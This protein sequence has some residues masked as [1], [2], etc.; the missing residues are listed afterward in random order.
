MTRKQPN[1]T[2]NTLMEQH[3]KF[4]GLDLSIQ[5]RLYRRH[6]AGYLLA[7]LQPAG[8]RRRL[9]FLGCQGD[10]CRSCTI[11]I[12]K[13]VQHPV[14][15]ALSQQFL[16]RAL[17]ANLAVMKHDDLIRSLHGREAVRHYN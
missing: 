14:E 12:L 17:L 9:F 16:V 4:A 5:D 10:R 7:E 1:R 3:C 11:G 15:S 2:S 13:L 6:W 8:T